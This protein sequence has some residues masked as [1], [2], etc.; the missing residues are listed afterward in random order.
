MGIGARSDA[1]RIIRRGGWT[2]GL[3]VIYVRLLLMGL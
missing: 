2:L 1:G 3:L